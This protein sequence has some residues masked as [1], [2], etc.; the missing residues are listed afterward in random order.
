[1]VNVAQIFEPRNPA[2]RSP[3]INNGPKREEVTRESVIV[4]KKPPQKGKPTLKR[5]IYNS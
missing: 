1:M 5:G 4:T 3:I 2:S